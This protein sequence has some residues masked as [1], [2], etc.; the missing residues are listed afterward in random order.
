LGGNKRNPTIPE[1]EAAGGPLGPSGCR[2]RLAKSAS[3][4]QQVDP[5]AAEE[6]LCLYHAEC[7]DTGP[8]RLPVEQVRSQIDRYGSG[9]ARGSGTSS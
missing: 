2:R 3:T 8:A 5:A 7:P 1:A 6:F 4:W 9:P